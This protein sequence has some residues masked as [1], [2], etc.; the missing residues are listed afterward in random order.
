[1][2][3]EIS[4]R[5]KYLKEDVDFDLV[6][7]GGIYDLGILKAILN[8]VVIC[9][10]IK[11]YIQASMNSV[12]CVAMNCELRGTVKL[13]HQRAWDEKGKERRVTVLSKGC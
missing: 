5:D 11:I 1:M 13:A 10:L 12:L 7:G 4:A 3:K 9:L 6:K 8:V 2:G